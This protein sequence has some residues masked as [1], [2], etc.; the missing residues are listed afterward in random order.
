M[1]EQGSWQQSPQDQ[2]LERNTLGLPEVVMAGLV[3]I[4]PAFSVAFTAALIA[5][6]AG[7]SVPFVF[8]LAMVGVLATGNSLAQFS[9]IWPSSG[10]FVTFIS[11]AL[12]P[13]VG[14][15]VA[16]IALLGYMIAFA[17]IY[18]FV[19]NLIATKVFK[20]DASGLPQVITAFYGILVIVPVVVGVRVGLRAAML[21]YAFEVAILLAFTVAI[22]VQG[23]AD[24][25]STDA[26]TFGDSI[27]GV[28]LGLSLAM[29]G[30]LGFEAPVPLA[31]ESENPRRNVPLAVMIS[32][33]FT[34]TLF[35]AASYAALSAFPNAKAFATD[36][37]PFVTAAEKF[38]SPIAGLVT[39]LLLASVTASFLAANTETARVIF[40]GAREGLWPRATG[41]VH[42]RYK[43]PWV[44]VIVF[45]VPSVVLGIGATA[46]TDI[47]TASGFLASYGALG[48]ILMYAMTNLA[49]I[50]LWFR[51][52]ARG[53]RRPIFTWLV[54]PF[55]GVAV[56]LVPYWAT[57]QPGQ[58]SPYNAL[59]WLFPLLLAIGVVYAV[60][61]QV[62]RPQLARQ[63]G[64]I[65]MGEYL[66]SDPSEADRL[67]ALDFE[68]AGAKAPR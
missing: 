40:S 25:L 60:A 55:I 49:L 6:L 57:F 54:V 19:G 8:L 5:G 66:G 58:P 68:R 45:V 47:G 10:S 1:A 39:A 36:P 2:R 50:V 29:L 33:L 17:G 31:E 41:K 16:I 27:K 30:F 61:L 35:V 38:I 7:A 42:S 4:A 65:V 52:R 18:V 32:I 56:M 12:D 37:A 3:Q 64:S 51:E 9:R 34:G 62:T 48:A 23:G 13:R 28:A 63:A 46:F 14:V 53:V 43:T 22:L 44:A 15:A 21:L 20:S 11:R 26:F 24:G 67:E 59:P